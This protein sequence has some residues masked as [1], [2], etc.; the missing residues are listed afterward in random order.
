MAPVWRPVE[1]S[2]KKETP[3]VKPKLKKKSTAKKYSWEYHLKQ[4]ESIKPEKVKKALFADLSKKEASA[5]L[6]LTNAHDQLQAK[7][8]KLRKCEEKIMKVRA[9]GGE[10]IILEGYLGHEEK[11]LVEVFDEK[12][13]DI[14]HHIFENV[15]PHAKSFKIDDILNLPWKLSRE[16]LIRVFFINHVFY[17]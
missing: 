17:S 1:F 13:N 11:Q 8:V 3:L 6:W 4:K 7:I 10:D 16:E 15:P 12:I 5:D 2:S 14:P 9:E